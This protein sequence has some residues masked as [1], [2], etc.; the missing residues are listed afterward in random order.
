MTYRR[1]DEHLGAASTAK[2]CI[3]ATRAG[4]LFCDPAA[5]CFALHD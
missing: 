1:V 5:K 3:G 4:A 2:R